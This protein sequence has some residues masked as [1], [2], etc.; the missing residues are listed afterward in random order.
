MPKSRKTKRRTRKRVEKRVMREERKEAA[1][2]GQSSLGGRLGSSL[3]GLLGDFAHKTVGRLFGMGEYKEA[4]ASEVGVPSEE[5]AESSAPEVNSLVA[6]ISSRDQVP[7]MHADKEGSI[8]IVRREFIQNL[9]IGTTAIEYRYKIN[10]GR[11]GDFPW[12]SGI[13]KSFAQ[14]SVMGFAAEYVPTSGVAVASTSAALGTVT[15][16]FKPNVVS[17]S[18]YPLNDQ[19]ALL[20]SNGATS[21]SPAACGACYMECAPDMTNQ[22]VKYVET[23][24]SLATANYSTQNYNAAELLIRTEGAQAVT[25]FQCGQLWFTYEILLFQPRTVDP[26]PPP[27]YGNKFDVA[28]ARLKSLDHATGPF[29]RDQAFARIIELTKLRS[30]LNSSEYEELQAEDQLARF[31]R[32]R[33]ETPDEDGLSMQVE[34]L[35]DRLVKEFFKDDTVL[36]ETTNRL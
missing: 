25:P 32:L 21:C 20:N 12:L 18:A 30:L 24:Q 8:R 9:R 16:A 31:R 5:V 34:D 15:M 4:L 17:G 28:I 1:P 7:M 2:V 19:T 26:S 3:G 14:Y 23:E 35:L 6:P 13:A 22:M 10:P 27:I 33:L 29:T 36:L 11:S